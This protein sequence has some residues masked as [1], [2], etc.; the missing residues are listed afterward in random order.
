MT[1]VYIQHIN[2]CSKLNIT[3][4]IISYI[5]CVWCHYV[6]SVKLTLEAPKWT[7]TAQKMKFSIKD[8]VGKC[9]QIHRKLRIWSHLLTKSLMDQIRS[10]LRIWSHLLKKPLMENVIFCTVSFE[11]VLK[12]LLLTL[13]N[14]FAV[15]QRYIQKSVKHARWKFRCLIEFWTCFW[16]LRIYSIFTLRKIPKFHLISCCLNFVEAHNFHN[17]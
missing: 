12:F 7:L 13:N 8:L 2:I 3:M 1:K 14:C 16:Y 10:F 9:D 17:K 5:T 11:V 15:L 4:W 6:I